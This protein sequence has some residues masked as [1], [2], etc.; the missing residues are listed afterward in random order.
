M[1][2]DISW[3]WAEK[4]ECPVFTSA[5]V[6]TPTAALQQKKTVQDM[7]KA[8]QVLAAQLNR[9]AHL[10]PFKAGFLTAQV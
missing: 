6:W 3:I 5:G 2:R 9:K 7:E 10:N 1:F 8:E 4:T